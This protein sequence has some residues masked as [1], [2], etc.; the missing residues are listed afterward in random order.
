MELLLQIRVHRF[1]GI[2]Q[3]L[4]QE[5]RPAALPVV[6]PEFDLFSKGF[7]IV[8]MGHEAAVIIH[9]PGILLHVHIQTEE[10]LEVTFHNLFKSQFV[11]AVPGI[12]TA[13]INTHPVFFP[14]GQTTV[15]PGGHDDT[16]GIFAA[17]FCQQLGI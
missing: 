12:Q 16:L 5:G 6:V 7:L 1:G 14:E 10:Q 13:Y 9:Q 11:V 3:E 17:M 15:A 4:P 2:L 8:R